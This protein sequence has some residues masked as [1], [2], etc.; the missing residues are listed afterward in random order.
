M[1]V[2]FWICVLYCLGCL[3]AGCLENF[4]SLQFEIRYSLTHIN[5]DGCSC[6]LTLQCDPV[7]LA[8]FVLQ[9]FS[10][11]VYVGSGVVGFFMLFMLVETA[12]CTENEYLRNLGKSRTV[13]ES[14]QVRATSIARSTERKQAE[15][16]GGDQ[17]LQ[18]TA[19]MRERGR[20]KEKEQERENE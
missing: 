3:G 17:V 13:S 10:M 1:W 16:G 11:S 2:L 14:I 6:C 19:K 7:A 8:S 4:V 15:R 20:D 18:T 9:N 5:A 12:Y